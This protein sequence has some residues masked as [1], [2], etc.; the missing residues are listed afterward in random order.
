MKDALAVENHYA[1]CELLTTAEAAEY[2]RIS[3]WTLRHWVSDKKIRFIKVGR[4]VRFKRTH[5]DR[6]LQDNVHGKEVKPDS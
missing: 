4:A 3:E 2:L 5:L 1:I 6:F